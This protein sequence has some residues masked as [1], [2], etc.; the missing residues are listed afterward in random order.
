MYHWLL[1][2]LVK[3]EKQGGCEGAET[4]SYCVLHNRSISVNKLFH[5]LWQREY[6]GQTIRVLMEQHTST[7]AIQKLLPQFEKATGIHVIMDVVPYNNLTSKAL[8][9]FSQRSSQYDVVF[10][11]WVHGVGYA[12]AGYIQPVD[13]YAKQLSQYYDNTDFVPA[14]FNAPRVNGQQYGL[15][16]YGESTFLMYRKDLF[17]QYGIA[18]PKTMNDL[19]TAAQKIY[20]ATHGSTYGITLRGQQ[21]IQNAYVWS[22]FLWAFGGQWLK[23]GHIVIDSPQAVQALT[24]YMKLLKQYGPP[25]VTNFG[26]QE[27]RLLFQQG[28]AAM[29]IDATVNGAYNEDPTQSSIVGKVGYALIPTAT[30]NVAGSPSSLETH[31]LYLSK[32]SQ[33]PQAAWL[34][35]SWA[36][37]R[38]TQMSRMT[39]APDSGV[40][41]LSAIN[42]QAFKQR[43]GAFSQTMLNALHQGNANYLPQIAQANQVI[44]YAGVAISQALAGSQ[45]PQAALSAATQ[46]SNQLMSGG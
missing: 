23:N 45:M 37:S 26:W 38:Q 13:Q 16:V 32:F 9:G 46:Q 6:S 34:F 2:E 36:T 15:P 1:R 22:A 33:H 30:A 28:K 20:T 17:Q 42:S 12:Q 40:T 31:A 11:D 8:L 7:D 44:N 4:Y 29:T 18:L 39:I 43:Y 3:A 24:F 19:A 25:G 14:Y 35:M 5:N 27:N 41:S 21:G 10:D